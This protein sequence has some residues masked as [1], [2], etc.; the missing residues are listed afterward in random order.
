MEEYKTVQFVLA[1]E[2]IDEVLKAH[3]FKTRCLEMD[4]V[5][6]NT[7]FTSDNSNHQ[8]VTSATLTKHTEVV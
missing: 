4:Q 1:R 5:S 3:I 6:F 8:D 2:E 7:A